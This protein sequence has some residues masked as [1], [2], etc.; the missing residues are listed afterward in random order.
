MK[1]VIAEE[2]YTFLGMTVLG[3]L[4]GFIFDILRGFRKNIIKRE[5]FVHIT[6]VLFWSV[7]LVI[8]MKT[9]YYFSDGVLR[10][11]F[12]VASFLGGL[13]Y[14]FTLSRP[15][16]WVFSIILQINLKIFKFIFKILL[17]PTHFL[18]KILLVTFEGIMSMIRKLKKRFKRKKV[19]KRGCRN[20]KKKCKGDDSNNRSF[21]C[22]CF[23][24]DK[25]SHVATGNKS[26]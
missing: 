10:I 14:F 3:A 19:K 13:L 12:V 17:T 2:V 23:S 24:A 7:S 5:F 16:M 21:F 15:F 6:D 22:G 26:E 4:I 11:C 8:T 20:D 9:I 25:R 1:P 18:Y